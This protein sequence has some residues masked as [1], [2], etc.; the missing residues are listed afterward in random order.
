MNTLRSLAIAVLLSA[1]APATALAGPAVM[2]SQT[3]PTVTTSD[4]EA[5]FAH[6]SAA[7]ATFDP[8]A[9]VALFTSDPVLLA[10]VSNQPRTTP[11][12]VEDY[13]AAFLKNKPVARIDSST[14]EI[15]CQTA[16]RVGTWTVTLTDPV[17][18]ATRE[19]RARYTFIYR[20]E[21]GVWKIDHLHSSAMPEGAAPSSA[22]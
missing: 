4:I 20:Y 16:S 13:F 5:Q 21:D 8:D 11:A 18:A 6:F 7:W 10:T 12:G 3:C 17:T 22:H 1:A 2:T 9:V 15:D 19:V 14:T